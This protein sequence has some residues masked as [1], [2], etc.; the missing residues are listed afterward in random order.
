MNADAVAKTVS[1]FVQGTTIS[2]ITVYQATS[3]SR[4]LRASHGV[5]DESTATSKISYTITIPSTAS[6]G[7]NNADQ[8]YTA[9]V[10]T[11]N[12]AISSGAFDS[13]LSATAEFIGA[14]FLV[15]V[16]AEAATYSDYTVTDIG[17]TAPSSN[18]NNLSGGAIAGIVIAV[19]VCAG[20]LGGVGWYAMQT[21]HG[22]ESPDV[23]VR[24]ENPA[25]VGKSL[26]ATS[27][28]QR[29][30]QHSTESNA[31][32][33]QKNRRNDKKS[34]ERSPTR[35][36][37]KGIDVDSDEEANYDPYAENAGV[38]SIPMMSMSPKK[39]NNSPSSPASSANSP[40]A[41]KRS[42]SSEISGDNPMRSGRA[43]RGTPSSANS[44]TTKSAEN[45]LATRGASPKRGPLPGRTTSNDASVSSPASPTPDRSPARDR[46][47]SPRS[48][49]QRV[50]NDQ[51][52][53]RV[54]SRRKPTTETD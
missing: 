28:D 37:G 3:S 41:S 40:N 22:T 24:S 27:T 5:I 4:R 15:D 23:V 36:K 25:A 30:A 49:Q 10:T 11:L 48:R 54:N 12:A 44:S 7:F 42:A 16:E 32:I 8:A 53:E 18:S 14:F 34:T 6:A 26:P 46:S 51:L 39:D 33:D 50:V 38:H 52:Q 45:P 31:S 43:N 19:L 1:T 13:T 29:Q 2:D 47:S 35:I 21:F 17:A 9:T 20:F